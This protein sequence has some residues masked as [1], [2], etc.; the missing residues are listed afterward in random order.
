MIEY[1]DELIET[2]ILLPL[3]KGDLFDLIK[4]ALACN[5]FRNILLE[6]I[7]SFEID[8]SHTNIKDEQI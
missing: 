1:I 8:V 2:I 5:L 4:F 7:R 6:N 3:F